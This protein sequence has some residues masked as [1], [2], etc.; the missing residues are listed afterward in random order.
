LT[1]RILGKR[2]ILS[3]RGCAK[4][5]AVFEILTERGRASILLART[6]DYAGIAMSL[7][8]LNELRAALNERGW[9]IVAERRREDDDDIRCGATWEVVRANGGVSPLLLIDFDGCDWWGNDLPLEKCYACY[10][11]GRR[12]VSLYFRRINRSRK[13][14]LRDLAA[15]LDALE[16]GAP[17]MPEFED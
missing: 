4:R 16:P 12:G 3:R 14:W 17:Q 7:S 13:L 15:F 10:V 9:K 5:R 2:G 1:F 11:R 8:H 6:H